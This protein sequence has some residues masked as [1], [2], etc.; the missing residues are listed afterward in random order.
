MSIDRRNSS[1]CFSNALPACS[2]CLVALDPTTGKAIQ[3]NETFTQRLG[4]L[5]KF[6]EYAFWDAATTTGESRDTLRKAIQQVMMSMTSEDHDDNN[7]KYHTVDEEEDSTNNTN[8]SSSSS[9]QNVDSLCV[10]AVE[11]LTLCGDAGMPMKRHFDWTIG[12]TTTTQQGGTNPDDKAMILLF[13]TATSA[14]ATILSSNEQEDDPNKINKSTF[15]DSE[16]V[17]FFVS[18]DICRVVG[19]TFILAAEQATAHIFVTFLTLSI[20]L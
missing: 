13:G 3:T 8:H 4:P 5:Y 6:Q 20:L 14:A 19:T 18:E 2:I 10:H 9:R 1:P 12:T 7:M 11:M 17:D 16:F 15:K